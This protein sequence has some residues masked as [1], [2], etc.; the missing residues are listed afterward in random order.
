MTQI[1]LNTTS[2]DTP[3]IV[4]TDPRHENK[5]VPANDDVD[6]Q[7]GRTFWGRLMAMDSAT[8]SRQ[9]LATVL[10]LSLAP[11]VVAS[12]AGYTITQNRTQSQIN[13]QLEGQALLT[14]AGVGQELEEDLETLKSL[15]ISPFVINLARAAGDFA[16]TEGLPEETLNTLE[17]RFA[18]TRQLNSNQALNAYLDQFTQVESLGELILSE[19]NGLTVGYSSLPLDFVQY[20]D[21]WWQ[22]GRAQSQWIGDPEVDESTDLFGF[23]LSQ[24]IENPDNGELLG[25]LKAFESSGELR[26]LESL[27]R[28]AGIQGSQQ[29]QLLDVSSGFTFASFSA[30]GGTFP[31]NLDSAL[32]IVGGRTVTEAAAQVVEATQGVGVADVETLTANLQTIDAIQAVRVRELPGGEAGQGFVVSFDSAGR[33]YALS[34]VPGL[35]WV[36][37]ASMDIAE[38]R[39]QGRG[40]LGV[41][42]LIA[43]VLG[44]LAA[45]VTVSLSRRLSSPLDDLSDKAQQVSAGNLNVTA[46]PTGTIET[47]SLAQTFNELVTRV[48]GFLGEQTLNARKA[49]FFADITG[50]NI[51]Q[52]GELAGLFNQVVIEA[53]DLLQAD[54][55]VV[56]QF[57]QN[58][59]GRI[60][61]ESVEDNLPSALSQGLSDPCIPEETRAKYLADRV[62]QIDDVRSA[63]LHPKHLELLNNLDVRSM[64]VVAV[65]AQGQLHGLMIAHHCRSGYHWQSSDISFLRQVGLQVGVVVERI[66]LLEQ[67]EALAEEQRQIKEGLQS[68]ALQLLMDVDPV[69]RGDLTARAKV[70][71]DEIGTLADSYN[72]TISSLRKIVSQVKTAAEQVASTTSD[73]DQ[74]IRQLSASALQQATEIETALNQAQAMATSVRQVATN[75]K[76]AELAVQQASATVQQ[77]D[78]AMNRT[79][80]GIMAIR[81]TVAETAKKVKRLGESSQKISNVVN[82]ISG[83]AAQT[84]M[85][86]LNASIEASRAGEGG[87]GFA[88]VAEE[89]RELARQSAEAT[90]E[91]EK[92]VAS[93]QT[94]T[95][96]VVQAMEV[97]TKQ[98]VDG[99]ELVDETR[100]S[101]NRISAASEQIS[102]LVEAITQATALQS[103]AS[104]AVTTSMTNVAAIA[105]QNSKEANQVSD[106]FKQLNTVAQALQEEVGRF[107]V[108]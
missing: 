34:T 46:E 58:W 6:N 81:E 93:I 47:Q 4:D 45:L 41:F 108:D 1:P 33:Q 102:T 36:A 72:A 75:A 84:N 23:S 59:E 62:L 89:V 103:N 37:I 16:E 15:V 14:S 61:A 12:I 104:D 49:K 51:S 79:V 35:D 9:L 96:E 105:S 2:D 7:S 76:E 107:K 70:T 10:P 77:G 92:L 88:V 66:Q 97:G 69:S 44:G 18:E 85:L 43:V 8:L 17:N 21:V 26:F 25:V 53:R 13:A 31:E 56:Y 73:N 68:N 71:E 94:E 99:T 22:Q 27:L 24:R 63:E 20:E 11:L 42:S 67:T 100:Q 57:G 29:V 30:A 87:K 60:V 3:P 101:L 28:D 54:R 32:Q 80:D 78:Q 50:A 98:V 106:S 40:L 91:I 86:A 55:M 5:V 83:F 19:R 38:I 90:T 74:S 39:A 64:A 52:S 65:E 82:L 48:K 95:N